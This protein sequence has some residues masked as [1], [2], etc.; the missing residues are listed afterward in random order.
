ML[1]SPNKKRNQKNTDK[2]SQNENQRVIK[3][4][5]TLTNVQRKCLNNVENS[6]SIHECQKIN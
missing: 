3:K 6:L 1:S 2:S 4:Q 5:N